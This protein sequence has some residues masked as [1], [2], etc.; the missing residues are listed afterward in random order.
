MDHTEVGRYWD[1]NAD[2]WTK[3]AR[4]GYDVSR[5]HVNTPGFLEMLPHVDGLTGIDI[6]C[7]EGANTRAVADLGAR[8]T[9]VDIS[10]TFVRH[11][12]SR[13]ADADIRFLVA[14]AVDLP[15]VD[16]SFDFATS[17]MCLMDLGETAEALAE[18]YRVLKP[19][20]F[21]QFSITHP[22]FDTPHRRNLRD[23]EGR[24]YAIEIGGYFSDSDGEV[25]EWFFGAAPDEA[26]EGLKPF[27]TPIFRRTMSEWIN[28]L[29]D[30]GFTIERLGEPTADEETVERVPSLQDHQVV[31]YFLHIRVR[32]PGEFDTP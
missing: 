12:L 7:G 16:E 30:T 18:A 22:C 26:R 6:G 1:G 5:D 32:K 21:L 4:E 10:P 9:A 24:T 19:G 20:G 11:A 27:K 2:A 3:L 8:M 17:F 14:S 25:M 13:H 29:I 28:L 23:A 15:F 31:A